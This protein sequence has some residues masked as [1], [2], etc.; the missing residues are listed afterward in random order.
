VDLDSNP[1]YANKKKSGLH[2]AVQEFSFI[3]RGSLGVKENECL[4]LILGFTD[5]ET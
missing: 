1:H 3:F 2:D 5:L 4:Y